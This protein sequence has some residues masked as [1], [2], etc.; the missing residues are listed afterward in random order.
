MR[1]GKIMENNQGK[2]VYKRS[3]LLYIIEAALEYFISITVTGAYLATLTNSLGFSDSLTGI[4]TSFV[5][6]GC[7]FQIIAIFLANKRPVKRWVTILH[8]LNQLFFAIVYFVPVFNFNTT[9]KTILFIL[10]LLMGHIL[11]NI[12]NAPKINWYMSLVDDKQRGKFTAN[13]EISSL[14]GGMLFT[15]ALSAVIDH[16]KAVGD[17]K[18]AFILCGIGIVLLTLSHTLTLLFSKEKQEEDIVQTNVKETIKGLIKDKN[19]LKV[20]LI[21]VFWNIASHTATPFY[22]SYQ[23]KELNFS[24]TFISVLSIITAVVRSSFSRPLGRYA[25]KHSFSKMLNICFLLATAAFGVNIFTT[26]SNGKVL[27]TIY[28]VLH[29]IAMAGINS[30]VI[31][32]IYD[33]VEPQQRTAALALKSAFAGFAGF[34]TTLLISPLVDYIQGAGNSI[35]G[36]S[37]YAQQVTSAIAF[38]LM[39][40]LLMYMNTV[41]RKIKKK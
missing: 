2:D 12:V 24:M 13:K 16:F 20:V 21:S 25:D 4:L 22:G 1:E 11:N 26:P 35:F 23:T 32:L 38:G 37:V 8:T 15:F 5:S 7:G 18:T 40:L 36:L 41:I 29:A 39:I 10:F 19:L 17:M 34:F 14:L 31:N 9:A 6:L 28:I 27:F 30:S 33:Y 3:R